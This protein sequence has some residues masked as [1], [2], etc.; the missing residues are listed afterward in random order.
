MGVAHSGANNLLSFVLDGVALPLT[1]LISNLG[2][3]LNSWLLL[4]KK[5]ASICTFSDF[6]LAVPTSGPGGPAHCY[7]YP[8]D[9]LSRL[10]NVLLYMGLSL[11]GIHKLLMIKNV[12]AWDFLTFAFWDWLCLFRELCW[13]PLYFQMQF[14]GLVVTF[15]PFM[16]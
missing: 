14:K 5:M 2:V 3:L 9:L 10:L 7:S 4:V 12:A 16:A 15:K 6:A 8:Y 11:K 1:E 13:L